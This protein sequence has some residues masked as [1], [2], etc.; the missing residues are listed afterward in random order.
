MST[1]KIS[2]RGIDEINSV[3]KKIK[4]EY[5]AVDTIRL[6]QDTMDYELILAKNEL[7]GYLKSICDKVIDNDELLEEESVFKDFG[8]KKFS[9]A[10]AVERV[11]IPLRSLK[12]IWNDLSDEKKRACFD[13]LCEEKELTPVEGE[14]DEVLAS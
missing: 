8:W 4:K 10:L 3:Y 6:N 12:T 13:Y 14:G 5:K 1:I 7:D 9:A 11:S 2:A